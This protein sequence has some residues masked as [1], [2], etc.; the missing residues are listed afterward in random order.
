VNTIVAVVSALAFILLL[1]VLIGRNDDAGES[2]F[3]VAIRPA[4]VLPPA[5]PASLTAAR[6]LVVNA[7]TSGG[8][9]FRV[10]PAIVALTEDRLRDRHGISLSH[11][12]APTILGEELWAIVR[13]DAPPADDRMGRGLSPSKFRSLLDR[14]EAL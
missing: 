8:L 4:P 14:L 12:R 1:M 13:P 11:P 6:W 7:T 2:A 10:R 5:E 3:D 9:H